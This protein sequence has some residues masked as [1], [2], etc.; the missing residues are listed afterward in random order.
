MLSI[1]CPPA[2]QLSN[3]AA[4]GIV[5][6][7]IIFGG[8]LTVWGR[9]ASKAFVA[10]VGIVCGLW[11]AGPL[12]EVT[13]INIVVARVVLTTVLGLTGAMGD[14]VFWAV[15]FATM[16]GV[17]ALNAVA[18]ECIETSVIRDF[19]GS[20]SSLGQWWTA[21]A[22]TIRRVCRELSRT[23]ASSTLMVVLPCV[24]VPLAAG[25]CWQRL[26]KVVMTAVVGAMLIAA[27]IN[28]MIAQTNSALWPTAWSQFGVTLSFAVAL[29]VVAMLA[30]GSKEFGGKKKS[31]SSK[32]AKTGGGK[33]PTGKK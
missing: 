23:R 7:T 10:V 5:I 26:A 1:P 33:P 32:S 21:L 2:P 6:C 29:A 13:G 20:P 8:I 14:S 17:L 25:L 19:M 18:S 22:E 16:C 30:M 3:A 31:K 12:S 15:V 9:Q 11:L 28:V 27:G 24:I 4:S